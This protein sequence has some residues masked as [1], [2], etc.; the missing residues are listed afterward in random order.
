VIDRQARVLDFIKTYQARKQRPPTI[1][2]I[3]DEL[4]LSSTDTVSR[5]LRALENAGYIRRDEGAACGIRLLDRDTDVCPHPQSSWGQA[6]DEVGD[7]DGFT[8]AQASE[9][10]AALPALVADALGWQ[11]TAT[12]QVDGK[13]RYVRVEKDERDDA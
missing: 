13:G 4:G 7:A 10:R 9:L 12:I 5:D 6:M 2:I 8:A 11:V 1:R 3:R